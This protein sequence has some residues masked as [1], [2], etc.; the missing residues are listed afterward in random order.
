MLS[1]DLH[2]IKA[3]LYLH[4]FI[5]PIPRQPVRNIHPLIVRVLDKHR[6]TVHFQA[7]HHSRQ[8]CTLHR[9]VH[10]RKVDISIPTLLERIL[11]TDEWTLVTAELGLFMKF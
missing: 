10:V 1:L 9:V 6:W 2:R 4:P 11:R 3:R 5:P 8:S 7:R